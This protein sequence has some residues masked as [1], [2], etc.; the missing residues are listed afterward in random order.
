[1]NLPSNK[2]CNFHTGIINNAIKYLTNPGSS[3][4]FSLFPNLLGFLFG[5]VRF[6]L[7]RTADGRMGDG[8]KQLAE[9][10][11]IFGIVLYLSKSIFGT[12]VAYL[13][14]HDD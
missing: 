7:A 1:V 6:R 12:L 2:Y 11:G 3:F 14:N 13:E 9:Y 8:I 4:G 5:Q 10:C